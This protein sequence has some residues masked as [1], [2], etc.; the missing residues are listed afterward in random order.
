[1]VIR[2][3]M[4]N[5][6]TLNEFRWTLSKQVTICNRLNFGECILMDD[7]PQITTSKLNYLASTDNR[8]YPYFLIPEQRD[9]DVYIVR[10]TDLYHCM[11][12][13]ENREPLSF[14]YIG[15]TD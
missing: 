3:L 11:V 9:Q 12:K 7:D 1:M 6:I 15:K 4:A 13:Y 14:M 8:Y 5:F 10:L 2:N